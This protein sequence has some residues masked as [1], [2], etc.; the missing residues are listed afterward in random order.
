MVTVYGHTLG[1]E[2][3]TI[4]LAAVCVAINAVQ[5]W[6]HRRRVRSGDLVMALLNGASIFPFCAMA[7]AVFSEE[8]LKAAS[9][10]T[11]SLALAGCVGLVFVT[12]EVCSP[13]GLKKSSDHD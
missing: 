7:G 10:S 8:L 4:I 6:C 2:G 12:G 9:S 5:Q 3:I 1:F 13:S 11:S